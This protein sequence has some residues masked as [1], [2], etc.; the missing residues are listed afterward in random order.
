VEDDI[1]DATLL[2]RAFNKAGVTTRMLRLG[3]GDDAV[4]YLGGEKEFADRVSHPLPSL[5]LLDIKLPRRSGLEVLAWV[6]KQADSIHRL[7]VV[8]LTSSRQSVDVDRAYD[9][10][11]N[12]YL[13]KP[14][15]QQG[16][17]ELAGIFKTYWLTLNEPPSLYE[18]PA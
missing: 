8:M 18:Q 16:L 5:M 9:L 6:R 2:Q 15:T 13:V 4:A 11:V 1:A 17:S 3:N 10:G 7:P 12:S 14:D